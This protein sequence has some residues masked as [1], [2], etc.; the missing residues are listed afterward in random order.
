MIRLLNM[1]LI[2]TILYSNIPCFHSCDNANHIVGIVLDF[3]RPHFQKVPLHQPHI[4]KRLL[5]VV[6][7]QVCHQDSRGQC[8]REFPIPLID[9]DCP[10]DS[11]YIRPDPLTEATGL[12]AMVCGLWV[13]G[14]L[15]F[16]ADAALPLVS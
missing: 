6:L 7:T 13:E 16:V 4:C 8:Q 2:T 14:Q 5:E 11:L 15:P 3:K 12:A 10:V 9:H 1:L